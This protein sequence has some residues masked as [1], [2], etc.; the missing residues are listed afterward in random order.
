M[1]EPRP[2]RAW[3]HGW[4]GHHEAQAR[5]Q[6][7]LSLAEKLDWLEEAHARVL[8]ML[9]GAGSV[10]ESAEPSGGAEPPPS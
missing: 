5:R 3:E 8:R 4:E 10:R 9:G 6:A 7:A 1:S 2:E